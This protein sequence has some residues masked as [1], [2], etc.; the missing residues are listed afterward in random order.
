MKKLVIKESEWCQAVLWD[1]ECKRCC[2][3][4]LC[5]DLGIEVKEDDSK[6]YEELRM[7]Y[8]ADWVRKAWLVNDL[9]EE[10]HHF[11]EP[12]SD[13]HKS[14]L[15]QTYAEIGYELEFIKDGE[16]LPS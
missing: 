4:H 7:R 11:A 13:E 1:R 3:G 10:Y 8:N 16:G 12:L 6:G 15:K 9:V 2:L 5:K 14:L